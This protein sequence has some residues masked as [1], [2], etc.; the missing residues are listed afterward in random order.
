M[1]C[2]ATESAVPH[3]CGSGAAGDEVAGSG[4]DEVAR[5]SAAAASGVDNGCVWLVQVVPSQ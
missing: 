1:G 2:S 4:L 5:S 3:R